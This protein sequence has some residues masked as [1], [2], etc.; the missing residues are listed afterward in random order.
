MRRV[1]RTFERAEALIEAN[2]LEEVPL[3]A[4]VTPALRTLIAS[5]SAEILVAPGEWV[6]REGDAAY[7]WVVLSGE[8][9]RVR[10][11]SGQE[12]QSTTF[13]PTEFFGEFAVILGTESFTSIRALR[14]SRLM[15]VD[16][17]DL[18]LLITESKEAAAFMAQTLIRRV[19]LLRD[20]YGTYGA[21]QAVVIGEDL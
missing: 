16:P 12:T 14:P 2:E 10:L 4:G 9:E 1:P 3:F 20:S 21:Q 17:A 15:R 19:S 5:R 6:T 11:L 7:L 18:H 8:V 13:D